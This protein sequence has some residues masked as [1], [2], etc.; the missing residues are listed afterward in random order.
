MKKT[1]WCVDGNHRWRYR[2]SAGRVPRSCPKHTT[3]KR[4][5][6]RV[7]EPARPK[8]TILLWCEPGEHAWRKERRQGRYPV[9]CKRHKQRPIDRSWIGDWSNSF[10]LNTGWSARV[11]VNKQVLEGSGWSVPQALGDRLGLDLGESIQ[12]ETLDG[13]GDSIWVSRMGN[14]YRCTGLLELKSAGTRVGDLAFVSLSRVGYE[15]TVRASHELDGVNDLGLALWRCGLAPTDDR[16]TDNPWDCLSKTLGGGDRTK[17]GVIRRLR[18]RGQQSTADMI[19]GLP[20]GQTT[21]ADDEGGESPSIPWWLG[22]LEDR[23]DRYAVLHGGVVHMAVGV[24]GPGTAPPPGFVTSEG[25]L[26]W[27]TTSN[28]STDEFPPLPPGVAPTGQ[29][30]SWVRWARAE[31]RALRTALRPGASTTSWSM[32]FDS[33]EWRSGEMHSERFLE[34]FE[35]VGNGLVVDQ[36]S[37][38]SSSRSRAWP[39]S[40]LAFSTALKHAQSNG[41]SELRGDH[42]YG[43]RA[44]FGSE[45][46]CGC[47]LLDVLT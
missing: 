35:F 14:G 7:E 42:Q 4:N 20:L 5:P 24:I 23:T 38:P 28:D 26:I 34:V 10:L 45:D 6:P 40:S 12:L 3:S 39:V 1:L 9:A 19:E 15:V 44:R 17:S 16:N 33:G 41:L 30:S 27:R 8:K 31:H 32:A 11:L 43:F 21:V 22:P 25:G 2:A 13:E 36:L 29:N 37:M 46:K 47:S 18:A